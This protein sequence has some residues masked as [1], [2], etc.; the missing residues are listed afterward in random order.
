M[1]W[2]TI[3]GITVWVVLITLYE[4]PKMN[5]NQSKEKA[6]FVI[7]TAM[8]CLLAILLLFVPNIAGPTQMVTKFFK[9]LGKVL[10]HNW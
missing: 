2:T 8:G 9:P 6:A 7:L 4:W 1:K 3:A 5:R 10:E